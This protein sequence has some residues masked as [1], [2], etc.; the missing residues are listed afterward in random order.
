M[1]LLTSGDIE[2]NSG[3]QQNVN[4][5]TILSPGTNILLNFQLWQLGLRLLNVGGAGDCFFTAVPHPLNEDPC[6]HLHVRQ[7]WY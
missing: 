4:T 7:R 5:Q 2:L 3:P 6:H 1:K